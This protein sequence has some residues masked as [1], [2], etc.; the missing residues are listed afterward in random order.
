VI[1][2]KRLLL[3]ASFAYL[4]T[5]LPA[6]WISI[7]DDLP[8]EP[9]GLRT[10]ND[11]RGDLVRGLG[12]ALCAPAP[13]LVVLGWLAGGCLVATGDDRVRVASLTGLGVGFLCGMVAEPITGKVA[14]DPHAQA[15]RTAI[16]VANVVLPVVMVVAGLRHLAQ[17]SRP[18]GRP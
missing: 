12:S 7:R 2:A 1:A 6:A 14:A 9:L 5:A 11:A 3:A 16:V 4:A 18:A 17:T 10:G 8:G 13:M 15:D